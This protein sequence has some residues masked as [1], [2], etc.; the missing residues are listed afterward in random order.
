MKGCAKKGLWATA[1][2]AVL[3]LAA[4]TAWAGLAID[5]FHAFV[6][7]VNSCGN[8]DP[9]KGSGTCF[10]GVVNTSSGKVIGT[11]TA[12]VTNCSGRTQVYCN[13]DF[14]YVCGVHVC[15]SLYSVSNCGK[16][17]LIATGKI[18]ESG[19]QD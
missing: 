14:G 10:I 9:C 4:T 12:C 3:Y 8:L 17:L 1:A 11:A 15:S 18:C 16:A 7:G 19:Q 5:K 2:A 13:G 6:D